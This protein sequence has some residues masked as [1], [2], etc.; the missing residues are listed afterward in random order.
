[1]DVVVRRLDG[2]LDEGEEG[3]EIGAAAFHPGGQHLVVDDL[4]G[5]GAGQLSGGGASHSVGNHQER[6]LVTH[7]VLPDLRCEDG[8]ACGEVRHHEVVLVV[9]PGPAHVGPGI[10]G[11][12]DHPVPKSEETHGCQFLQPSRATR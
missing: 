8:A 9:V 7:Q 11:E 10:E 5:H 3:P 1:V 12:A 2:L 4:R 6:A